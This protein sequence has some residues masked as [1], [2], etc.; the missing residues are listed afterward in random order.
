MD[1]IVLKDGQESVAFINLLEVVAIVK[2]GN[3]SE[4]YFKGQRHPVLIKMSPEEIFR[5]IGSGAESD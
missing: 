2:S 4:I 5:Q 1:F 3:D